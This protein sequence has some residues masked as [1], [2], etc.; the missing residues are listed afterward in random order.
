VIFYFFH[1]NFFF[2]FFVALAN[3]DIID[4]QTL[5]TVKA[6][7]HSKKKKKFDF[8]KKNNKYIQFYYILFK[9]I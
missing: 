5:A 6:A 7:D 2:T 3:I 1:S 8:I 4:I 9:I